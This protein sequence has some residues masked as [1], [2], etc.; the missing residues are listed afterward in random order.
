METFAVNINDDKFCALLKSFRPAEID[1]VQVNT[2][3]EQH[4]DNIY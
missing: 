2:A 4:M 1:L 3:G